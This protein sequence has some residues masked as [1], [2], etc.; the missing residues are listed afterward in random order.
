[1]TAF[2]RTTLLRCVNLLLVV[3]WA[4]AFKAS[5]L[6]VG[7][8]RPQLA[9]ALLLLAS[10]AAAFFLREPSPAV[11]GSFLA[12]DV[13]GIAYAAAFIQP[14]AADLHLGFL[15]PLVL[16]VLTLPV[17]AAAAVCALAV[18]AVVVLLQLAGRPW[19]D[20]L[21]LVRLSALAIVPAAAAA[22]APGGLRGR[23]RLARTSTAL[24]RQQ[25]VAEYITHVLFQ[26]REYL[27]SLTSVTEH[28]AMAAP[29]PMSK[30]LAGK[31]RLIVSEANAK[32]SRTVD[33]VK[34]TTTRKSA[35]AAAEFPLR[36]LLEQ[37][38]EASRLGAGPLVQADLSCDETL[39][40]QGNR[41]L[42]LGVLMS[43]LD[44][45]FEAYPEGK[46][47]RVVL[48]A[49]LEGACALVTLTDD[50]GG[51]PLDQAARVYEPLFTTKSEQGGLGLG[52]SMSRLL[53]ERS[54][55][56]LDV[57][58]VEGGTRVQLR[59]PLKPSLPLIRNEQSTWAGR[60]AAPRGG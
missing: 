37:A 33:S 51:I 41:K 15:A 31:M 2:R 20:P 12:A 14:A 9:L 58:G 29:D 4:Q 1:V 26:V 59:I 21:L 24:Q 8:E 22:A 57:M 19:L 5:G 42:Y 52:V 28:L 50:A 47:G 17:P 23:L 13:A 16:A 27:T 30:D 45:A 11:Q 18:A 3:L 48:Q 40:I 39:R 7:P 49:G 54:G 55:G 53:M 38:L 6:L 35:P 25:Q 10:A 60:R 46:R 36:G 34:T 56:S 43:V 44:N 32:I